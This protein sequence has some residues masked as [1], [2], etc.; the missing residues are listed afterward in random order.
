MRMNL[1]P[2][3][4]R[5]EGQVAAGTMPMGTRQSI[6]GVTV[7]GLL[8]AALIML[9]PGI[10]FITNTPLM[11]NW[12][13]A[14]E[15]GELTWDLGFRSLTILEIPG[16]I[17]LVGW[18]SSFVCLVLLEPF[19]RSIRMKMGTRQS[20]LGIWFVAPWISGFA[21]FMLLPLLQSLRLSFHELTATSLSDLKFRGLENYKE[22]FFIDA[23]FPPALIKTLSLNAFDFPII[24]I[25]A[26]FA[27]ILANQKI[28]GV[29][30]FRAIFFL[31]LIIGSAQVIRELAAQEVGGFALSQGVD[32]Q[33]IV[34]T[35][36]GAGAAEQVSAILDRIIF[37]LWNTSVQMLVFLAGL[38]SI[39]GTLY[40][41]AR[42][43]GANDWDRFWKITLP[44]MTPVVLV[45]I[46]YTIVNSFTDTFNEVLSYVQE[47]AFAGGF[48]L[49]Y[50]AALGW[51]Y[52]LVVGIM[53]GI[54]I[55]LASRFT[56]YVGEQQE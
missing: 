52:F 42:V 27:A 30:T 10:T 15:A 4:P 8:T 33:Q 5:A 7:L 53:L 35:Y 36:L 37:V 40:E 50:A 43:D 26:L 41:A 34:Y 39:P 38:N 47:V 23:E 51:V 28:K 20:F 14:T 11:D 48:R 45:N 21:A 22:A 49:G 19:S 1:R 13:E 54:V 12:K 46:V 55:Y 6:L 18:L 2:R 3:Q 32:W 17:V 44:L 25:F 9:A 24:V 56:F 16:L 29:M 31:P